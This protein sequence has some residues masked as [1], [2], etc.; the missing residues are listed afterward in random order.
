MF[1]SKLIPN[2]AEDSEDILGAFQAAMHAPW[3]ISWQA[4]RT[5]SCTGSRAST[6]WSC[7][8]GW[9]RTQ[10]SGRSRTSNVRRLRSSSLPGRKR[11]NGA[12]GH[13][14][15]VERHRQVAHHRADGPS[16]TSRR[17]LRSVARLPS[18][19]NR[20]SGSKTSDFSLIQPATVG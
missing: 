18:P 1:E 14:L 8:P 9:T 10:E 16:S 12:L 2:R 4:R 15:R 20:T 11:A 3:R 13:E 7:S 5:T 17:T 6:R 19:V